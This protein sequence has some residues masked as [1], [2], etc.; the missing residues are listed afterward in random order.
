MELLIY[1]VLGAAAGVISGLFGLGGGVIIVPILILAFGMQG[2]SADVATHLALG[3]S[4]ATIA[5]TS[6]PSIYTHAQRGTVRW[7]L[8]RWIS[9]GIILGAILGGYAAISL[10]AVWLQSLLG[11]FFVAVAIQLLLYSPA[12]VSRHEPRQAGL[13]FAGTGIGSLSA[14]FGIGGGSLTTPFLTYFGVRIHQAVGTAAACGFPIALFSSLV[15]GS[16]Q[17]GAGNLPDWSLGLIFLPAWLGIVV[18]SVP[19][20][21]FGALIAHRLDDAKLKR[22]F[23]VLMLLV[24]LRY[25][26]A[27][28]NF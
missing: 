13:L 4:L 15:Y 21:R 14:L 18:C 2:I 25:I 5:V 23:A 28:W 17:T 7:D 22:L 27:N 10:S 6:I 20:A 26:W 19:A 11:L 16:S 9:P 12:Q 24:G 3:T 8:V 1:L